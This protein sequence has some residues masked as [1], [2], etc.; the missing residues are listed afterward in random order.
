VTYS[1]FGVPK[2]L[3][4][5]LIMNS[6]SHKYTSSEFQKIINGAVEFF[7]STPVSNLPPNSRFNGTGFYGIYYLGNFPE[8]LNIAKKNGSEMRLPIYVGKAVPSGWRQARSTDSDNST[9]LYTRLR[10][11]S[12]SISQTNLSL[13][14]FK[15][16]F[17][18]LENEESTL[19]GT[20]EAALIRK[21]NPLWNSVIDGFGN[22]DPGSGR[23]EQAVSEWDE[24]HPGRMWVKRLTGARPNIQ[25]IKEKIKRSS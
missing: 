8:Y 19:I 15:C 24:L 10:E 7:S 2:Y 12:R 22:H 11:H 1:V 3:D 5:A 20:V 14:D 21:F 25:T 23:Y 18:I 16:R 6:Q 9:A 17:I 4:F 13:G